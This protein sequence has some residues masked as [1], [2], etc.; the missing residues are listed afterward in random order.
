MM[1]VKGINWNYFALQSK[2]EMFPVSLNF[3]FVQCICPDHENHITEN[4][5][6]KNQHK[7]K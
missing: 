2:G 4:N 6:N 7:I 3:S 1:N 5:D